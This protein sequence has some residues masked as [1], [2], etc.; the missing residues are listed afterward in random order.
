MHLTDIFLQIIYADF[1][2]QIGWHQIET[3]KI[4]ALK[5]VS[6]STRAYALLLFTEAV[7]TNLLNIGQQRGFLNFL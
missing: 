3:R 6:I 2:N 7:G 1:R 4:Q 5:V